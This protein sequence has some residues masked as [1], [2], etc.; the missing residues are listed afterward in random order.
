VGL[1]Q[2]RL[3][4][5]DLAISQPEDMPT[6]LTWT[7]IDAQ[8]KARLRSNWWALDNDCVPANEHEASGIAEALELRD[9]ILS[10]GGNEACMELWD[11][12]TPKLM[13]RGAMRYGDHAKPMIGKP[14]QCHRNT[15][16]L[17]EA[18]RDKG[19]RIVT[20]YALSEDGMWRCHSWIVWHKTRSV[21]LI[22]T[23]EPRIAYFGYEMTADE[24]ERF[25]AANI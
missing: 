15:C 12:D 18:N 21:Q 7:P 1:K 6:P 11:T 10:F 9:K 5:R 8:W 13:E 23:T 17:Y 14:I 22:E 25:C 19:V 4:M 20:G 24:A 2:R 16:N 3:N